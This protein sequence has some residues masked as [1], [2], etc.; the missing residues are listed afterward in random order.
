M[1]ALYFPLRDIPR[2]H[3]RFRPDDD[4]LRPCPRVQALALAVLGMQP[5]DVRPLPSEYQS[6][7]YQDPWQDLRRIKAAWGLT[8]VYRI[9]RRTMEV[10]RTA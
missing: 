6:A 10:R 5:G 3:Y 2:D 1:D 4:R 8:G 9:S 7:A